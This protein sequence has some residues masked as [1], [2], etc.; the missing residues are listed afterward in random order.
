MPK[1]K[2]EDRTIL[3]AIDLGTSGSR[4]IAFS[5]RAEIIAKAYY[6]FPSSF[7]QPGWVE[8]D[9][10]TLWQTT[11]RALN[12]VLAAVPHGDIISLGL[13]NQRETTLLWDRKTGQPVAPAIVWQDRR[14]EPLCR[15]QASHEQFVRE[16][17]GLRLDPYFSATKIAWLMDHTHGLSERMRRGEICFGTPDVWM[18]WKLTS[19]RVFATE[20]SNAA[21][22]L[23]F[24]IHTA[25]WDPD[26]LRLF[27][28]PDTILPEVRDSD[29]DFGLTE[30]LAGGVKIPIRGILGDQQAALFAQGAWEEGVVKNT[31]GTGLFLLA[32]TGSKSVS[33]ERLLST[34]AWKIKGQID[35]ALEGSILMGAAVLNWLRDQLGILPSYAESAKLAAALPDNEGVYFVPALQGLG[36]PYWDPEARGAI[37]GLT[38]KTRRDTLI[39]AA[40]EALA[41]QSRDVVE[42]MT[43]V[44]GQPVR[45][46]KADGGGS[47]NDFLMQ[48]QADILGVP[49]ERAGLSETTALGAAGISGLASGVWSRERF[50]GFIRR[51]N[52][53]QPRMPEDQRER[54]YR[55]WKAAVARVT[56][57]GRDRR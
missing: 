21:R 49:V 37:F 22:T 42:E 31:Y 56:S 41:Y 40:L 44:L 36:A 19:G 45:L 3:L 26:L 18:I 12:E 17:T 28:I 20:P 35:Y 25:R 33:S 13:T 11:A 32:N 24:N 47:E 53:I 1:P 50:A 7:P 10:E 54:Y 16:R 15:A 39:R 29:A 48:F 52:V 9:P 27:E 55:E 5:A 6:E 30:G 4:V 34:I 23:L 8:Q 46:L 43:P 57:S 38:R 51:G 14:T 2:P